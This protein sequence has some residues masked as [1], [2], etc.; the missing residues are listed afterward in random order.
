M[1]DGTSL[2]S[3]ILLTT[4]DFLV[5]DIYIEYVSEVQVEKIQPQ[6]HRSLSN[7]NYVN[8]VQYDNMTSK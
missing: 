2:I 1:L 7:H 8:P 6:P 4:V 3:L 5:L